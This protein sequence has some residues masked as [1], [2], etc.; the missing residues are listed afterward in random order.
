MLGIIRR[1]AHLDG[2][3]RVTLGA[4]VLVVSCGFE[5]LFVS[6]NTLYEWLKI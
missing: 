1:A 4:R 5:F 2:V 3:A 6:P